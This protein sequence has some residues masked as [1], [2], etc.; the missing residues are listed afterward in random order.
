MTA[1]PT[2]RT[3]QGPSGPVR[4]MLLRSFRGANQHVILPML[5]HS[6]VGAWVG[7]PLIGYF[8]VLT[9]T[10]RRS[11]LPRQTPLNYAIL[12]GRVYLLCG[13]GVHA[14]WY[15]NLSAD[16][17]VTFALPGRVVRGTAMPV[18]DPLEAERAAL[19]VARNCGFALI[20]EG[21]N[22]LTTT[23]E[24]LRK[25]L[26]GRPVVRITATDPIHPGRH[27]PGAR[28]WVV[29]HVLVPLALVGAAR[30]LRRPCHPLGNARSGSQHSA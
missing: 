13:F 25:Q 12:D 2:V 21:M 20:L 5:R 22:P 6:N 7:S 4:G 1:R 15:R 11:G 9:T 28:S 19:A 26:A 18:L 3:A 8:L 17:R 27:D 14:D 10:G 16:P 30:F 23:D 24:R 29:P